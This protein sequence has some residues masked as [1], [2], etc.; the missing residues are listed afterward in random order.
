MTG[1]PADQ[2]LENDQDK[3]V[4]APDYYLLN[5]SMSQKFMGRFEIQIGVYNISV[6]LSQTQAHRIGYQ[7]KK[8]VA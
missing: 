2:A 5:F 1:C 3:I 8:P 7:Q 4:D 6:F